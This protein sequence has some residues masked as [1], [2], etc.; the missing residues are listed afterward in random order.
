MYKRQLKNI[1][2]KSIFKAKYLGG[3][4]LWSW[5]K[6]LK[7]LEGSAKDN[8]MYRIGY[9]QPSNFWVGYTG[10]LDFDWHPNELGHTVIKDLIKKE[11]NS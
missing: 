9:N 10:R 6:H 8:P 1:V 5:D 11:L 4:S 2:D 7:K 3:S